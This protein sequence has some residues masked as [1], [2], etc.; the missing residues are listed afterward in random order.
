MRGHL[1]Y[2]FAPDVDGTLLIQRET[3]EPV[4]ALTMVS[5]VIRLMLA[6]RLQIRLDGIKRVLESGWDADPSG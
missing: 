2:E 4:G 6:R 5:P 3:L 1:A